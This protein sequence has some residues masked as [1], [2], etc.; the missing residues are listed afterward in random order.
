MSQ[1]RVPGEQRHVFDLVEL[2]ARQPV[3]LRCLPA[4]L[5]NPLSCALPA[6]RISL[7][8]RRRSRMPHSILAVRAHQL[9]NAGIGGCAV[10]AGCFS[11]HAGRLRSDQVRAVAVELSFDVPVIRHAGLAWLLRT[12]V[13][14]GNLGSAQV[15][16]REIRHGHGY[17]PFV[18]D[19]H[20]ARRAMS[21]LSGPAFRPAR[22]TR[23]LLVLSLPWLA[24][25][26]FFSVVSIP[27]PLPAR[28]SLVILTG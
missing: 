13:A 19:A 15:L 7:L 24:S 5:P 2:G 3:F 23:S 11:R 21:H 17:S 1:H 27:G 22:E 16:P 28:I 8:L 12:G 26:Y 9:V 10:R 25:R 18:P 4:L 14:R 20:I 6:L